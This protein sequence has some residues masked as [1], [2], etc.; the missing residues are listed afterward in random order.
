MA[1]GIISALAQNEIIFIVGRVVVGAFCILPFVG[2]S[3]LISELVHPRLRFVNTQSL[4]KVP[5]FNNFWVS[6]VRGI[7]GALYFSSYMFGSIVAA[8]MTFSCLYLVSSDW[9]WRLP[10]LFQAFGPT[11]L[12]VIVLSG[13]P[14]SPTF[15]IR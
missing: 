11:V 7:S 2:C 12:S 14:E 15:L 4:Y 8:W 5:K 13:L 9:A 1:G 10:V 6:T 3:C